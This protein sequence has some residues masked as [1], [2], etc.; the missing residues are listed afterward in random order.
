M[1]VRHLVLHRVNHLNTFINNRVIS[2]A[3]L[4]EEKILCRTIASAFPLDHACNTLNIKSGR[5]F[6]LVYSFGTHF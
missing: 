5:T 6:L 3:L 1:V 2:F 4:R